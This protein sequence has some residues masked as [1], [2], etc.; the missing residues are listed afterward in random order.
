MQFTSENTGED[1]EFSP[2][3][4]RNLRL[5]DI[6]ILACYY[7]GYFSN[8]IRKDF[9]TDYSSLRKRILK[10]KWILGE[11][12]FTRVSRPGGKG[13]IC[14][15]ERGLKLGK[16]CKEFLESIKEFDRKRLPTPD[17]L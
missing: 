14:L 5:D 11:E 1:Y 9:H 2:D 7:E 15:S 4:L 13:R 16:A 3:L 17:V 12:L 10:M 8:D 6:F